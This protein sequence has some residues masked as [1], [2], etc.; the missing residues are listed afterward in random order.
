[1]KN[2]L[3][4]YLAQ[5]LEELKTNN[6]Y[7]D[8]HILQG[9]QGNRVVLDGKEMIMLCSNNYLGLTNHPRVKEAAKKAI[10]EFGVGLGCG[11]LIC[12]MEIQE[13]LENKIAKY[14]DTAASI[15]FQTGYDTN[16]G[17]I[18]TLVDKDDIIYSDDLN[19]ASIIDGCRFSKAQ[20]RVYPHKDMVRLEEM[21]KQD[22]NS[23]HKFIISDA[24]FSMDGDITPLRKIVELANEYDAIT[25]VDDAHGEGVLGRNGRGIVDHFDLHGQVTIEMATLS[26]AIGCT[27][28]Y[29][30]GSQEIIDFLFR[31]ARPFVF[32]TGHLPP[33]TAAGALAAIDLME[34]DTQFV[35]NLWKN[36]KYFK[37]RLEEVGFDYGSS[38]T[39]IVPIIVG[40]AEK[41]KEFSRQLFEKNIYAQAFTYPIVPKDRARLRIIISATH[42]EEDLDLATD[43]LEEVGRTL[44]IIS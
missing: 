42:T 36:T 4:K 14:R 3:E 33:A 18:G 43:A 26:K 12:S 6:M 16:L 5:Q 7:L 10:D 9:E 40:A 24:V 25:Y 34:S 38:E 22:K 41:A 44:S 23:K 19:H 1:M 15:V 29:I 2:R 35:D 21:M 20:V 37:K 27:G 30:A 31:R 13:E 39:P 8:K 17:A 11:R 32:S 28:G